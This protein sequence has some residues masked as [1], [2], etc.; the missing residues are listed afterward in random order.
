MK[1]KTDS[2]FEFKSKRIEFKRRPSFKNSQ[3]LIIYFDGVLGNIVQKN[4]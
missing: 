3:L 1:P 4:L 2:I